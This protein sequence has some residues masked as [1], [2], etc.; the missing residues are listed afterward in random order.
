M[1]NM[2][3]PTP[4]PTTGT[5]TTMAV[6]QN[7]VAAAAAGVTEHQPP[8]TLHTYVDITVTRAIQ[9]DYDAYFNFPHFANTKIP[10]QFTLMLSFSKIDYTNLT[11]TD[12]K[13]DIINGLNQY[14][15]YDSMIDMVTLGYT[16]Y[17]AVISNLNPDVLGN[18]TVQPLPGIPLEI[19]NMIFD[20]CIDTVLH[21][22]PTTFPYFGPLLFSDNNL[23]NVETNYTVNITDNAT[24]QTYDF[25]VS[26]QWGG[27]RKFVDEIPMLYIPQELNPT[28][29]PP[30][31]LIPW[32][33]M[34]ISNNTTG[35]PVAVPDTTT[36]PG[37]HYYEIA[38]I[39]YSEK[40]HSDFK[41]ATRCR[42]FIQITG[43][44]LNGDP[45]YN[46]NNAHKCGPFIFAKKDV[47]VRVKFYNL[48]D[49]INNG[50]MS[51]PCDHTY[52]G[53]GLGP[54][55]TKTE[56]Y[57]ENRCVIHLH[58]G[59]TP[60]NSDG[61]PNQWVSAKGQNVYYKQGDSVIP[62]GDMVQP[63]I[64]DSIQTYY[65][66]N[67]QTCRF[68]WYH[69]HTLGM[70]RLQ[71]WLGL[72]SGYSLSDDVE[73]SL[74]NDL[75][76]PD[77]EYTVPLI[78]EEKVFVPEIPQLQYSDPT[79]LLHKTV[80]G[81]NPQW[82]DTDD[83][84][85]SHVLVPNQNPN[86]AA[87]AHDFGRADYGPWFWP[88]YTG[89]LH[90]PLV[91]SL[92]RSY[93]AVKN[94]SG[95]P[96]TFGDTSIVNG[97]VYPF[98]KVGPRPYRFN[99]LNA[100]ND[101]TLNLS[102]FKAVSNN[103]NTYTFD[104][105]GMP[106]PVCLDSGETKM[107]PAIPGHPGWPETWPVDGRDGGAP[108]PNT[109]GP[110]MFQIQNE[111]G[112]IPSVV[113]YI[114]Q[115]VTF[116]YNRRNIVVL[117]VLNTNLFLCPAERAS[118]VV[119][120]SKY[121]DGDIILL[122]ND[123]PCPNPGFDPRYD[124]YT[125]GPDFSDGGSA[126]STIKGYG[127]NSRTILQ[128]RVDHSLGSNVNADN[129]MANLNNTI[130]NAY[131]DA[132][133]NPPLIPD[134][135]YDSVFCAS[136]RLAD[137]SL[138]EN[139]DNYCRID[140][141]K[142]TFK[143]INNSAVATANVA[144][145]GTISSITI[146]KCGADY[147]P[148]TT[149][150]E[151]DYSSTCSQAHA[152]AIITQSETSNTYEIAEIIVSN[153]G[154]GYVTPPAV[155]ISAP[156]AMDVQATAVAEID[157]LSGSI[158]FIQVNSENFGYYD[159]PTNP[160]IVTVSPP[161]LVDGFQAKASP[162]IVNGKITSINIDYVG[163]YYDSD[164]GVTVTISPPNSS[165]MMS[166]ATAKAE[167]SNG[168]ISSITITNPGSGYVPQILPT[169]YIDPPK[170]A[171]VNPLTDIEFNTGTIETISVTAPG[172]AYSINA[173][174]SIVGGFGEGLELKPII[175]NNQ[176]IQI[177]VI[178][179]G[180]GYYSEPV[181]TIAAPTIKGSQYPV[182]QAFA[183]A[184]VDRGQVVSIIMIDGGYGYESIPDTTTGVLTLPDITFSTIPDPN[185]VAPAFI[186]NKATAATGYIESVTVSNHGAG[187]Y[188]NYLNLVDPV[189]VLPF[190]LKNK[191]SLVMKLPFT[192]GTVTN[193]A[194]GNIY[195]VNGSVEYV[196]LLNKGSGYT[197]NSSTT[198]N[199]T[200][201]GGGSRLTATFNV[202]KI[203]VPVGGITS[204]TINNKGKGFSTQP[205][206]SIVDPGTTKT[207]IIPATPDVY[208]W[209]GT[210]RNRRWVIV[211]PAVPEQI[212][213]TQIPGGSGA[214]I[215]GVVAEK[216]S[217]KS[218]NLSDH[219]SNYD[220]L[221][222]PKVSVIDKLGMWYT[223]NLGQ[224]AIQELFDTKYGRMNAT[225]GVELNNTNVNVQTTIPYGFADPIAD[226]EKFTMNIHALSTVRN[227]GTKIWKLTHNGVD[228]HSV[229][230][231]LME[232]QIINRIGWDGMI[233]P[234][235]PEEYGWK[236]SIKM[237]PLQQICVAMRP[238]PPRMP[239][240]VP[241]SIRCNDVTMME[242]MTSQFDFT[243]VD[244]T[245][246]PV[247]VVNTKN[248]FGWEYMYHCHI[249]GHEENDMMRAF[250]MTLPYEKPYTP[251]LH[252]NGGASNL[253]E[254]A[255]D[256]DK[257]PPKYLK[258]DPKEYDNQILYR[259]TTANMTSATT[260]VV[261]NIRPY[262]N[263]NNKVVSGLKN[264]T[265][266]STSF[267]DNVTPNTYYYYQLRT[268][269]SNS[270]SIVDQNMST[271]Y[272]PIGSASNV[273]CVY[274]AK[275]V[276]TYSVVN[277]DIVLSWTTISGANYK[278]NIYKDTVLTEQHSTTL[279]TYT[280]VPLPSDIGKRITFELITIVNN[281]QA[282]PQS[283]TLL[284]QPARTLSGLHITLPNGLKN[285]VWDQIIL[286]DGETLDNILLTING[287]TNT[288]SILDSNFSYSFVPGTTY[289]ISLS[290][291]N[292]FGPS[293][294]VSIVVNW[295]VPDAPTAIK[296]N[297]SVITWNETILTDVNT[298][299][300]QINSY[301][302][303]VTHSTSTSTQTYSTTVSANIY[304]TINNLIATGSIPLSLFN[305]LSLILNDQYTVSVFAT[306]ML[307]D[308]IQGIYSITWSKPLSP[309]ISASRTLVS[310]VNPSTPSVPDILSSRITITG[311]NNTT[312]PVNN[313]LT[314]AFS[315]PY[316]FT[317]GSQ[318][319][320]SVITTNILGDSLPA[321]LNLL[322][323]VPLAPTNIVITS[324][325][326]SWTRATPATNVV[327][328]SSTVRVVRGSGFNATT[329]NYIVN[330][331]ATSCVIPYVL[332]NT[333]YITVTETNSVG[334]S[335]SS[336][337][338]I[339]NWSVPS[340]ISAV[341]RSIAGTTATFSWTVPTLVAN[342][343]GIL[344]YDVTVNGVKTNQTG[345]KVVIS[346]NNVYV[347]TVIIVEV[348]NIVG[349]SSP[350]SYDTTL[351]N[352]SGLTFANNQLSWTASTGATSYDCKI[353]DCPTNA[354]T[355]PANPII[356]LTPNTTSVSFTPV[357]GK[358]YS[359][360][361]I[362]KSAYG[363]SSEYIVNTTMPN[364]VS[365]ITYTHT[366]QNRN[367]P[368]TDTVS[369][370]APV[371]DPNSSY[372]LVVKSSANINMNG[373]TTLTTINNINT[374]TYTFP[375]DNTISASRYY[376]Y[377]VTPT[378]A[379][380]ITG[381]PF[382]STSIR[383]Q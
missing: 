27:V 106:I 380:G 135:A 68:M 301:K 227:D 178:N 306:N 37:D 196:E 4:A 101:R 6:T 383:G 56:N 236:E 248:N 361:I 311:P 172:S 183:R 200:N 220:P 158:T 79:W 251:K 317:T 131:L 124:Y 347:N 65:Y 270:Y 93:P 365:N 22:L 254:I 295:K 19:K 313:K 29:L 294:P 382:T 91:D 283:I 85:Y 243:N 351:T 268:T 326:I 219:G 240:A 31:T 136:N 84:W 352:P 187:Y 341:N 342:V 376:T 253:I 370:N 255:W 360:G 267:F 185:Y 322:P 58:G 277:G 223:Y 177:K 271:E 191:N 171:I 38:A 138:Y 96:E 11:N 109:C 233:T 210:G 16:N 272:I 87:G 282:I 125:G 217:I 350:V 140:S 381:P 161:V 377:T 354:Y 369:W 54:D 310:W 74:M 305:G 92:G 162:I 250:N 349:K 119:D 60:W 83:P 176:I 316:T 259:S 18:A 366:A 90:P 122:Y 379:I 43:H 1:M 94:P 258:Y 343:P 72:V 144:N 273:M 155:Y 69:D 48:L 7:P 289:N 5:A 309:I 88:P 150:V 212:I 304:T 165:T 327:T 335:P 261:A 300:L 241:D 274:T 146:D 206:F 99:I 321:V 193:K 213:V 298:S 344:S 53:A 288:L 173:M 214:E 73:Q 182:R 20:N 202:N 134:V 168:S 128:F 319:T 362:A 164:C 330:G 76:L 190:N 235:L 70:T 143:N 359:I 40:I 324:T 232:I 160:V 32:S 269:N 66:T 246:N 120:F 247:T 17:D 110:H 218:I 208:G 287:V 175:S 102:L 356:N 107:L 36:Y 121:S 337:Q 114:N 34:C 108:D 33:N 338:K 186:I 169:I 28:N 44:L 149:F 117:D 263:S 151:I 199:I 71:V 148:E 357:A 163:S 358:F 100:Y 13:N 242:G 373:S 181:I 47:P 375:S 249:L 197:N 141:D 364:T 203:V 244:Q 157:P 137:C 291:V 97:K 257:N 262:Y 154:S 226:V 112:F 167:V 245:G 340:A 98:M 292:V 24:T 118:V 325:G 215:T 229:H 159:D 228:T 194:S 103:L 280:Y 116:E 331:P 278:L 23:T 367:N 75:D 323:A 256:Y 77:V 174:V 2:P 293:D 315:E 286:A 64:G 57:A 123:C 204:V 374:E 378:N 297:N 104:E 355:R 328:A 142:L 312:T 211:T 265:T 339:V 105:M 231:H 21:N 238:V 346:I 52:M 156:T 239:Y 363:S 86:V 302:I 145:D 170:S 3:M 353:Y 281:V 303:S 252:I 113:E 49:T 234:P 50:N 82:G 222:P 299:I 180:Y 192:V 276:L 95:T 132:K 266:K 147:I 51:I 152:K 81:L 230:F 46:I 42:G 133:Q 166:N 45:V 153:P 9:M 67:D 184:T 329:T 195:I 127:P 318:Y 188:G 221:F 290:S 224:P 59:N 25:T 284:Y 275:P 296:L 41:K 89:L 126:P 333:Y 201:T 63:Q 10:Y 115:P 12:L 139:A 264:L 55:E 80:A 14:T 285:I 207:T 179:H 334:I 8:D 78:L 111:C 15:K 372:T 189:I 198:V 260:Q 30:K 216:N 371:N 345:T 205:T 336:A 225:F 62:V 35:I 237:H 320:I 61:T 26:G 279:L 314:T 308:S 368:A 39:D 307:G 129:M 332:N 209:V 348:V 130:Q